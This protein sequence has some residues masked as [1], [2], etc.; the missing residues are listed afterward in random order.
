M[1]ICF[2]NN[3]NYNTYDIKEG[4]RIAQIIPTRITRFNTIIEV[5]SHSDTLRGNGGF[6]STGV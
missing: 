1:F 6:G 3:D 2:I 5:A 4:D